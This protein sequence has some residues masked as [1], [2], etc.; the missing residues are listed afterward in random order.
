MCREMTRKPDNSI[1]ILQ[2]LRVERSSQKHI[3][4]GKLQYIRK[5]VEWDL[6]KMFGTRVDVRFA[7]I[8]GHKK[9]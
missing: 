7:I 2:E 8:G 6:R 3:V 1:S 9:G 4:L 5:D